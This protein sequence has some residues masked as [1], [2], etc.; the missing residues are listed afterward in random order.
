[1]Q[2]E[3]IPLGVH[4]MLI[5]PGIIGTHLNT[6]GESGLT[7]QPR[8][9]SFYAHVEAMKSHLQKRASDP[10]KPENNRELQALG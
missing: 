3:L 4:V 7:W 5:E 6:P 9:N 8:P 10:F 1:L 2:H